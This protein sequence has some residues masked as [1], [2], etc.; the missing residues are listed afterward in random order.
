MAVPL[1]DAEE[2]VAEHELTAS[3]R[4]PEETLGDLAVGAADADL[5]WAQRHL[6]W[7]NV[8]GA[9]LGDSRRPGLTGPREERQ[10]HARRTAP[11]EADATS[12][13]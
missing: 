7:V 2:L 4:D 3:G 8:V 6:A 12:T 1:D 13:R 5:E 10:R 9:D 11:S